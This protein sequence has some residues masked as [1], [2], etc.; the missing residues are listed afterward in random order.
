MSISPTAAYPNQGLITMG[1]GPA[2]GINYS[3]ILAALQQWLSQPITVLQTQE[4]VYNNQL[5]AWQTIG[6]D[7]TNLDKAAQALASPS[8]MKNY[9][10]NSSNT[11]VATATAS[12]SALP[13]TY[14]FTVNQ[15]AQANT[16]GSQGIAS[17]STTV[18]GSGTGTFNITVNGT[19]T[20]VTLNSTTGYTLADLA[21]AI[22]NANAGVSASIINDGSA[23]DPYRLVLTSNTTG[24]NSAISITNNL[25]GGS[26]SL[27]FNS[28]T[29]NPTYWVKQIASTDALPADTGTYTGTQTQTYTFT[30][31]NSGTVGTNAITYDWT[32]S[33]G[34]S[35]SFTVPS[36][37]TGTTS[38][39][40]DGSTSS[41]STNSGIELTFTNGKT[42]SSGDKFS[43]DAFNPQMVAA[44]NAVINYGN[45]YITSQSNTVTN[46]I[47][48]VTLSLV[49]TGSAS[50]TV[51][52]NS[53]AINSDVSSFISSYN[54]LISDI[55]SQLQYNTQTKSSGPLGGSAT[56][57]TL[58]SSL[59]S[60]MA[61]EAPGLTGNNG[62]ASTYGITPDPSGSGKLQFDSTTLDSILTS[63]PTQAQQYFSSLFDGSPTANGVAQ[64]GGM[65][66][67]LN[68]YTNP[69][70]GIIQYK[71]AGINSNITNLNNQISLE[72]SMV[73][74]QMGIYTQ[75]FSQLES[76][77]GQMN[78]TNQALTSSIAKLP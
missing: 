63:N 72:Q 40:I 64:A 58:K 76:Y 52:L 25:S 41:N 16:L 50:V 48:G 49:G 9:T 71:E 29:I 46:A 28:T 55:N 53:S 43:L 39:Y 10:A 47:P 37:E 51:A 17:T 26:V 21:Q 75:E 12:S 59:M 24:T 54:Q 66:T 77:I 22:N 2:S 14:S 62:L 5:S 13:G 19:T 60:F 56:L 23:N 65:V 36:T 33:S 31:Q 38:Y 32:N 69:A 11:S 34:Q 6:T 7:L 8:L 74:E 20:D 35:G 70:N 68:S 27:N 57:M 1:T 15:L 3:Q 78:T 30:A 73:Q 44:Q 18:A 4:G 67:Y 42:V 45:D 61:S